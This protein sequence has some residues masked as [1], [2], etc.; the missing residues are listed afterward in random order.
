MVQRLPVEKT[1]ADVL[2]IGGGAAGLT[3]ALEARRAGLDVVLVSKS[4]VGRSGNTIISGTGLAILD[5]RPNS[6]DSADI[7]RNDTLRSGREINDPALMNHFL[8]MSPELIEHLV[9]YGVVLKKLNGEL[10]KRQTPGHSV[11][12]SFSADIS[13]YPYMTRGLSLTL[14]LLKSA[15]ASGIR[16]IDF[17]PVVQLLT[18]DGRMAGAV[19]LHKKSRAALVIQAPVVII[20]G[21]GC[22]GIFARS[23]NT[24]DITGDSYSL[25]YTAG[26]PLRDMEFVQFYPSMMFSPLK[27]TISS[28]L[29]GDGAILR[30]ANNECFMEKY[31]PAGNMATRDIMSR[32]MFNEVMA[33]RGRNGCIFMDCR[34]I[35]EAALTAKYGEL[36]RLLAKANLDPRKDLIPISPAV[37]FSM[38]GVAVDPRTETGVP[39][40]LACGEAVGGLHGANRLAGNALPETF[41]FGM[42]AG[43]RAAQLVAAERA[44][45]AAD[46]FVPEPFRTGSRKLAGLRSELRRITWEGLSIIRSQTSGQQAMA[47]IDHIADSLAD[48]ALENIHDLRLYYELK[49]MITTARLIVH[50][51]LARK[52]SRGSH[53]RSDYPGG[54]DKNFKGSFFYHN[55]NGRLKMTFQA[56]GT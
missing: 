23:N 12:R 39:G 56:A 40:L 48:A 52:E 13:R 24:G 4:R 3:A 28:P 10:M 35:P 21:G 55:Q 9:E 19:A 38:G 53:Y 33:G 2:V 43:R 17:A 6:E 22:G 15:A 11:A 26:A 50:G 49:S 18:T 44:R 29:F 34:Q 25:A 45:P 31:D 27:V 16:I 46:R 20:A 7:F 47:G 37:H 41:I 5:A 51:C 54:D 42:T 30:N 1:R 8:K 36:L 14:P 32:A